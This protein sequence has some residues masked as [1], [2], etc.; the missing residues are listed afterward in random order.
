MLIFVIGLLSLLGL[1]IFLLQ[2]EQNTLQKKFAHRRI[3]DAMK[4]A[5]RASLAVVYQQLSKDDWTHRIYRSQPAEGQG[6]FTLDGNEI[7]YYLCDVKSAAPLAV[8]SP[9]L[10]DILIKVSTQRGARRFHRIY[11]QRLFFR[12][13][14][15]LGSRPFAFSALVEIGIDEDLRDADIRETFSD[16]ISRREA[17][18]KAELP[19]S[20]VVSRELVSQFGSNF[21]GKADQIL[22]KAVNIGGLQD[23]LTYENVI[24]KNFQ[25]LRNETIFHS[26]YPGDFRKIDR[27]L[28]LILEALAAAREQD[29]TVHGEIN[30]PRSMYLL[31]ILLL[32]T[33]AC[34]DDLDLGKLAETLRAA[35]LIPSLN[36]EAVDLIQKQVRK[37]SRFLSKTRDQF[38]MDLILKSRKFLE[39]TKEFYP[40]SF[41]AP[42]ILIP[43]LKSYLLEIDYSDNAPELK[44][45][46]MKILEELRLHHQGW[47]PGRG[48]EKIEENGLILTQLEKTIAD[49][50]EK[51]DTQ[52]IDTNEILEQE[53]FQPRY[54]HRVLAHED[55][56]WLFGGTN[57]VKIFQDVWV[58]R[59]G[60]TWKKIHQ[61][62]PYPRR[63]GH[64]VI[65]FGE[66]F[67]IIGGMGASAEMRNDI[68]TSRDGSHWHKKFSH[69][70]QATNQRDSTRKEHFY[71]RAF[72]NAFS[73]DGKVYLLGGATSPI[74]AE[75]FDVWEYEDS[76]GFIR[77][78]SNGKGATWGIR[79]FARATVFQE[80][81]WL[82]GGW[83]HRR[84]G[85]DT[86]DLGVN[87]E[88]WNIGGLK[89]FGLNL[90]EIQHENTWDELTWSPRLS[91]EFLEFHHRL[92]IIGG[93]Y[94]SN[95][96]EFPDS[97]SPVPDIWSSEDGKKWAIEKNVSLPYPASIAAARFNRRI[98]VL[99]GV[100]GRETE[101]SPYIFSFGYRL[102]PMDSF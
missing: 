37:R 77:L 95:L 14:Q 13:L 42:Y 91:H 73:L 66:E 68:W 40:A 101:L 23:I 86:N 97:S 75:K 71:P 72:F 12:S 49:Y 24:S 11:H 18:A 99:G 45:Q 47:Y 20:E 94:N 63:Y 90:W 26:R 62:Q 46:A 65:R 53:I 58:S 93:L 33:S 1:G 57:G 32:K 7:H 96:M 25:L 34:I 28:K 31:G 85:D 9:N 67:W 16:E 54:Q 92:W 44:Q 79:W 81:I 80:R 41:E 39:Q 52:R 70:M 56:L 21:E 38:A 61:I 48:H 69:D 64:E 74:L 89:K 3:V 82:S 50:S 60:K 88:I 55:K 51:L 19:R 43:L 2:G 17:N 102:R 76:R 98:F 8:T 83:V 22:S 36:L 27:A 100:D 5:A 87:N 59:D 29:G 30:I 4:R 6:V 10:T 84:D 78:P 35:S 15:R